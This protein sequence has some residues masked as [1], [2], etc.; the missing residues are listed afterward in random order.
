MVNGLQNKKNEKIHINCFLLWMGRHSIA[1]G[2]S[3]VC[4]CVCMFI[5]VIII[6]IN[7]CICYR[8]YN[9]KSHPKK[10]HTYMTNGITLSEKKQSNKNWNFFS[11]TEMMIFDERRK[12]KRFHI[13]LPFLMSFFSFCSVSPISLCGYVCVWL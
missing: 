11:Q 9:V 3:L 5:I 10:K 2:R 1:L 4:V 12:K 13:S 7:S 8:V 6:I